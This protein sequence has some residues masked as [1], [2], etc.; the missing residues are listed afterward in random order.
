M[1]GTG[2]ADLNMYSFKPAVTNVVSRVSAPIKSPAVPIAAQ[3]IIPVVEKGM[4]VLDAAKT[5]LNTVNAEKV[6]GVTAKATKT[7]KDTSKALSF[8]QALKKFKFS[9]KTKIIGMIAAAGLVA[10]SAVGLYE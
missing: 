2:I 10:A 5:G 7:I 4:T 8:G 1:S 9:G 6:Y 3:S